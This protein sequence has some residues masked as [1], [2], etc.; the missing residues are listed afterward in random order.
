MAC[1]TSHSGMKHIFRRPK[2]QKQ[3]YTE[4]YET[5]SIVFEYVENPSLH[6]AKFSLPI[7]V[8]LEA[9]R[10][11]GMREAPFIGNWTQSG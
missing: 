8:S 2:P 5:Y 11:G 4:T 1:G 9:A 3:F 10:R 7:D 6:I